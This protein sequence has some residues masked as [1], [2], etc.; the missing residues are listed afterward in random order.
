VN[1]GECNTGD[2]TACESDLTSLASCGRCGNSCQIVVT[3]E[4]RLAAFALG[5]D[6]CDGTGCG[7]TTC[8]MGN[9]IP[10]GYYGDPN[11]ACFACPR[12]TYN[13]TTGASSSAACRPCPAGTAGTQMGVSACQ[14]CQPGTYQDQTG[15]L[16]CLSCPAGT[17]Q[18]EAGQSGCKPCPPNSSSSAGA[19]TCTP[20][21]TL[22]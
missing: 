6:A 1:K 9:P 18:D 15:Q 10:Q 19:T 12:G 13:P 5:Y 3:A 8:P 22:N 4:P 11:G 16:A 17:Y 21:V 14:Q 2:G 20:N 7:Y